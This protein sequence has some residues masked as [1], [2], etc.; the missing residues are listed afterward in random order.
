MVHMLRCLA[1]ILPL[2][3]VTMTACTD[4]VEK[5]IS[6]ERITPS[7]DS[8]CGAPADARTMVVRALG[9]FG[10]GEGSAQS[11][12]LGLTGEF[13]I[14]RFPI[15]TRM[16]EV[17]VRGFAGALRAVGRSLEFSID[18]LDNGDAVPVFMA[19]RQGIC[20]TGPAVSSRRNP[21]LARSGNAVLIAG[22]TDAAGAPVLPLERYDSAS[23]TFIELDDE[24]YADTSPLGLLGAS[25]TEL[26]GGDVVIVGG[27]ATAYQVYLT[28]SST[29]SSPSFYREARAFH[30]ALALDDN[31]V[32]LAGG[33][34]QPMETGCAVGS[35]LLTSSLLDPTTGNI[36]A[37]PTL[38][39]ARIGGAAWRDSNRSVLLVGGVDAG[40]NPVTAAE[41]LFLDGTPGV[42]IDQVMGASAQSQSGAV[43]VGLAGPDQPASSLL[44]VVSP[45]SS[46]VNASA[47][48][49]FA[50]DDAQ[51]VSLEDGTILAL[52]RAGGQRIRSF[53]GAVVDLQLDSLKDREGQSAIALADGTVLIVGGGVGAPGPD[54]FVYRPALVGPLSASASVSFFS[55]ELSEGLSARDPSQIALRSETGSH[56]ELSLAE[57]AEEWLIV[58]GPRFQDMIMEAGIATDAGSALLY[59]GWLSPWSHWKVVV[60]GGTAPTLFEVTDGIEMPVSGCEGVA[61]GSLATIDAANQ[62]HEVRLELREERLTLSVGAESVLTCTL[63]ERPPAGE[64]GLGLR[65]NFGQELRVDL[66]SLG[67]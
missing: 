42:L 51:L 43:W 4:P 31:R 29:L 58:S 17:E 46:S 11:I 53:D 66:I 45:G 57:S 56:A 16:L 3:W 37:G 26:S 35:E 6:V 67:R 10:A 60:S 33:C 36:E 19:P 12:E 15:D 28:E 48:A 25:M 21:M 55:E 52:G 18:E 40:G 24:L 9:E 8:Q 32:F 13:S 59:F 50:D 7:V 44:S 14:D 39:L 5:F 65:G 63:D 30:A 41:R 34:T 2:M 62:V 22:G 38:A 23:A 54:A 47:S 1:R 64:A 61:L 20:P 27:A 49:A